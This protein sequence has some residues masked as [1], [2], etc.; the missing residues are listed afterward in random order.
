MA[1]LFGVSRVGR[2]RNIL[3]SQVELCGD[4]VRKPRL[5]VTCAEE[6]SWI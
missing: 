5:I 2:V 4:E 6:G 1:E 3:E